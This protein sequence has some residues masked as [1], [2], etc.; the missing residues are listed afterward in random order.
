MG[1]TLAGLGGKLTAGANEV[2]DWNAAALSVRLA[3]GYNDVTVT[4][5]LTMVH[6]AIHDALKAIERRYD[7]Y[8]FAGA[9]EANASPG[10]AVAT[11][12]RD[13]L[14]LAVPSLGPA[15]GAGEPRL[16]GVCSDSFPDGVSR[17]DGARPEDRSPGTPLVAPAD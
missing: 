9:V 10:A 5:G 6:I 1:L 3:G 7:G 14:V 17:R 15:G 2:V 12:A 11:A 16:A 8:L 13:V 4:R